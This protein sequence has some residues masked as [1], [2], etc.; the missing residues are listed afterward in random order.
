MEKLSVFLKISVLSIITLMAAEGMSCTYTFKLYDTY[1]DGWNGGYINI[2][3]NGIVVASN[4]AL[5]NGTGPLDYAINCNHGDIISTDYI[6]GS[7]SYENYYD[8]YD[9]NNQFVVRDGC[10]NYN[11]SPAGG[12]LTTANCAVR[13]VSMLKLLSPVT[14]CGLTGA[15]LVKVLVKNSAVQQIDTLYFSYSYDDGLTW[16]RDTVYLTLYGG[17]SLDYNFIQNI[18]LSSLG[19]YKIITVVTTGND[20]GGFNDT[21]ETEV[22]NLPYISTFPYQESFEA[23]TGGWYSEGTNSSWAHG[24]PDAPIIDTAATDTMAWVTN[25]TGNYNTNEK[26]WVVSPCFDFSGLTNIVFEMKLWYET[27]YDDGAALQYTTDNVN[28][29]SIGLPFDQTNWYNQGWVQG[30]WQFMS[31]EGWS[32]SSSGWV[33]VKHFLPQ[34]LAGAPWVRFRVI[35]GSTPYGYGNYEGVAFDDVRI[36]EPPP[37]TYSFSEVVQPNT[38]VVGKGMFNQEIIGLRI[39]TNSSTNPLS[40]TDIQLNTTGTTNSADIAMSRM[41][42]SEDISFYNPHLQFG[43]DVKP[44]SPFGYQDTLYLREGE[45]YFW[46]VYDVDTAATVGNFLDGVVDSIKIGGVW[47]TPSP[48]NPA[49]NRQILPP[50]AG[51]YVIDQMG[52]GDY[53]ILGDALSDLNNRG[54][55]GPVILDMLPGIYNEKPILRPVFGTSST[56][57]IT[58][59]SST[60]DS[61]AVTIQDSAWSWEENWVVLFESASHYILQHLN[62]KPLSP[63]YARAITL[64]GQCSDLQILHCL[65]E[66]A[67]NT[68]SNDTWLAILYAEG[69]DQNI[70]LEGNR[71]EDGAYGIAMYGWNGQS[72]NNII[73]ENQFENQ[74]GQGIYLEYQISPVVYKNIF[75]S[76]LN[77][78]YTGITGYSLSD[79]FRIMANQI[80]LSNSGM[81]LYITNC[82]GDTNFYGGVFNNFVSIDAVSGSSPY[83]LYLNYLENTAVMHNSVNIYNGPAP[84]SYTAYIGGYCNNLY[85]FNN[86]FSNTTTG[87]VLRINNPGG[88]WTN[89]NNYYFTGTQFGNYNY[90]QITNLPSWQN[91]SG[92][93]G[94][95]QV[96]DPMFFSNTDLHTIALA[97]SNKGMTGSGLLVD[98]D[99]DLRDTLHPD[100]GAD[101]FPEP[102]QEASFEGFVSPQDACGLGMEDISIRI[103]NNGMDPITGTLTASYQVSG[104]SVVNQMVPGTILPG[105]TLNFT[106]TTKAN[107]TAIVNDSTFEILSWISLIGDPIQYNDSGETSVKS[108]YV[109]PVPVAGNATVNY[110][111]AAVVSVSG[112]G[113]KRWYYNL[114]DSNYFHFGDTLN[115]VVLYDTTT[116]YVNSWSA[117]TNSGGGNIAPQAIASASICNTGACSNLNDLYL[118][119]CGTQQMW[120]STANP[121]D[122]T[123]HVNWIDFEWSSPRN[124][125]GLKI[126]HGQSDARLL[127]GATLYKWDGFNWISFH[128]FSNL[129]MQC[130]NE[131]V[132]PLVTTTKLRITSF[133]MTGVGQLNNPNFREIEVFEPQAMGCPSAMIPVTAYVTAFPGADAGVTALVQPA[134]QTPAGQPTEIKVMLKNYGLN[135][136]QNVSILWRLNNVVQGTFAW[137]GNL[138][139]G[140]ETMVTIDTAIFN[141]GTL[142]IQAYT[143]LPNGLP[144]NF[145]LN[146]TASLWFNACL[147]G[148]YTIGPASSGSYNYNTF[149]SAVTSLS[150]AGICGSVIFDVYPG[151]YTEQIIIPAIPGAGPN[152]TITFRGATPDSSLAILQFSTSSS[153]S[154]YTLRFNGASWITFQH[155]TLKANG[156]SYGRVVEFMGANNHIEVLNCFIKTNTT[157]TS[158]NFTCIYSSSS[159]VSVNVNLASNRLEGGYYGIYWYG[160][161]STRTKNLQVYNNTLLDFYRSG[162]YLYYNDTFNIEANWII[163]RP[164]AQVLYSIYSSNSMGGGKIIRNRILAFSNSSFYGIYLYNNDASVSPSPYLLANNYITYQGNPSG[165]A[166]GIYSYYNYNLDILYNSVRMAGGSTSSG[167]AYYQDYGGSSMRLMNNIFSNFNGGYA[168]YIYSTYMYTQVNNNDYYT[169]GGN[170]IYWDYT[171]TSFAGYQS[172]VAGQGFETMSQNLL[173][174]FVSSTNLDLNSTL[175]S[176]MASPLVNVT[177]DIF[178]HPRGNTP[179]IGAHEVPILPNDAGVFSFINP[180]PAT[181]VTEGDAVPVSVTITNYG[182]DPITSVLVSYRVNNGSPVSATYNGYLSFQQTDIFQLPAITSP[183]GNIQVCAWTTLAN[184]INTFNDT[185]CTSYYAY[186]NIDAHLTQIL[187]LQE[188]CGLGLDTV[189]VEIVNEATALLPA[190]YTAT[191]QRGTDPVVTETVNVAIPVGDTIIFT[192]NTLLSLNTSIDTTYTITAW[193]DALDDNLPGNDTA[194][195]QVVSLAIPPPPSVVSPVTIPFGTGTVLDANTLMYTEWYNSPTNAK[196]ASGSVYQTP[197]LYDTTIYYAQTFYGNSGQD[198]MIGTASTQGTTNSYPNPYGHYYWGNKEQYLI[199]ASELTTANILPGNINSVAFNVILAG[200]LP[201]QNFSIKMGHSSLSAMSSTFVTGLTEV[202]SNPVYT[203]VGGWN[204]H[205]FQTPFVWDGTSNVVVEVCFN[206]TSYTSHGYV[207]LAQPGFVS[208]INAHNDASGVCN[209]TSGSTYSVRPA[210]KM[211]CSSIGCGSGR[212]PVVVNVSNIPP[213]GKPD[214]IPSSMQVTLN[215]C[216]STDTR[217]IRIKNI[218]TAPLQYTSFGGPHVK[219]TTSTQYY[220]SSIYSDTTTH[221]FTTIPISVDSLFLEVTINGYYSTSAA[222]ASLLIEGTNLGIIPDGNI[223]YGQNITVLYAVGGTQLSN[224]MLDGELKVRIGNS[225]SVYPSYAARMHRVRA[226]TKPA[227]W[228]SMP[229]TTG[230]IPVGDSTILQVSFNGT[231]L[232]EGSY[233]ASIPLHFNHP[234]YPYV[235]IPVAMTLN[236]EPDIQTAPCITFD[237]IFQYSSTYELLTIYNTGC[238]TLLISNILVSDTAFIPDF[239]QATIPPFD[240]LDLQVNFEPKLLKTYLDTL[241]ILSNDADQKICLNA[242]SISPPVIVLGDDTLEALVT[243]CGDTAQL[244]LTISNNGNAPL[245]WQAVTNPGSRIV[246]SPD[247]GT[248]AALSQQTASI[249]LYTNGL[250]SGIYLGDITFTSNDPVTPS[251]V[252]PVVLEITGAPEIVLS[253]VTCLALDSVMNGAT[254]SQTFTII[255]NGCDTLFV[256]SLSTGTSHF[257]LA[258]PEVDILPFQQSL[259][260]VYFHPQGEGAFEDT[261]TMVSNDGIH[262]LCLTGVGLPAPVINTSQHNLNATIYQCNDSLIIPVQITNTGTAD[263]VWSIGNITGTQTGIGSGTG[264]KVGVYNSSGITNLLN[265]TTDITAVNIGSMD[266][267]TIKQYDVIMNIRGSNLN[268]ADVLAYIQAGGSWI[269][270]WSSNQ[271][272]FTWGAITGSVANTGTNGTYGANILV[273][274]HYLAQNINWASMPYGAGPTEF[275][276]DLRGINDPGA[277][278]IVTANHSSYPNNP[279]LVEK[280]YGSGKIMIFNWDY[281]DAPTYNS[282]VS[283]MII[284]VVRYAGMKAQW[285][286]VDPTADTAS[287]LGTNT[288]NVKFNALGLKSGTYNGKIFI[289]SNDPVLPTDTLFCTMDVIGAPEFRLSHTTGC[290]DFDTIIQ[291]FSSAK[292]LYLHNDGCDTLFITGI[293]HNWPQYSL[294]GTN[295]T[296]LPWD[297]AQLTITFTPNSAQNYPDTL[298]F[299]TNDGIHTLCLT[300]VGIDA[301]II[302]YSPSSLSHTFNTCNDSVMLPLTIYNTGIGDLRYNMTNL[303]GATYD[304]TSTANYTSSGASTNHT[305]TGVPTT[306][307]SMKVILT[308]NGD[309]DDASE[310]TSLI[311]EGTNIGIVPDNNYANGTYITAQ[312]SF[313][314]AQLQSWIINGILNITLANSGNV[315]HWSGLVSMHSVQVIVNG[316]PWI[317]V[318]KTAD[319]VVTGDSSIV[320]VTIKTANLNNGTYHSDLKILSNDPLNQVILVPC[321]LTVNGPASLAVSDPCLHFGSAMQYSSKKDTLIITNNGC[322]TLSISSIYTATSHYSLS[323][324]YMILQPGQQGQLIVTFAPTGVGSFSDNIYLVTGGGTQMVCLTG[325]GVDASILNVTPTSFSKTINTCN[326]TIT[327]I[328]QVQ[329]LGTGNLTYQVYGG[330]GLSGDSTVLV[331]RDNHP[332]GVNIEQYLLNNFGVTAQTILSSQIAAAN[333]NLYDVIITVGDQ[334]T[335]YYNTLTSQVAKFNTFTNSGGIIL[336]MLGNYAAN[337]ITLA[338]NATMIYGSS[339]SQNIITDASHPIVQGLSNPLNGNN[340]NANYLSNLPANADIITR[341]NLSSQPTT[342]QYEVG[343]GLVIA[344][345]M[346][347]EYNSQYTAYSMSP[348]MHNALSYALGVIGTSPSWMS[349]AYTSDTLFGVGSTNVAVNFNSTGIPNGV[350][351]SNIIV[352]SNDPV[353]PQILVPCTLNVNGVAQFATGS[354]CLDFDTVIQGASAQGAIMIYNTG[355]APLVVTSV[356]SLSTEYTPAAGVFTV[357]AGDSFFL[358]VAFAPLATGNRNSTL[359]I[360]SNLGVHPVCLQ[361]I[362]VNPPVIGVSP[363]FFSNVINSCSDTVMQTLTLSNTGTGQA[364]YHIMGLYGTDIDQSS[365]IPFVT[366]GAVTTHTFSNLPPN[367]D[368]LVLEISLSGDF[369]QA[370]EFATLIVDGTSIGQIDDGDIT[371]GTSFTDYFGFG[372]AQLAAMIAN[373]QIVVNIQNAS[374]VDHWSGLNSFHQVRL[375]VNGNHWISVSPLSDTIPSNSSAQVTLKFFSTN[376]NAGTHYYDVVIGS[377][378]PGNAQVAVPC[379]LTVIGNANWSIGQNCLNF[380]SIMVGASNMRYLSITNTGCDTLKIISI[381]STVLEIAPQQTSLN[382]MPGITYQLPVVFTP[383]QP[384]TLTGNLN[385]VSN[386]GQAAVCL[387]AKGLPAPTVVV[388]QSSFNSNMACALIDVKPM[389]IRN[390]GQ[391]PLVFSLVPGPGSFLTSDVWSGTILPGDSVTVLFTFNKTGI[392]IGNF[393]YSLNLNSNDPVNPAILLT[394]TLE[395][396]T[397]VIPV[398]LGPDQ[399]VCANQQVVLNAGSGYVSYLWENSSTDSVRTITTSG[400]YSITVM[401]GNNCPSSDTIT[402]VVH[403]IPVVNAGTDTAIC[404]GSGFERDALATGTIMSNGLIQIGNGVSYSGANQATPFTT[405]YMTARRQIIVLNNEMKSNG[406]KRGTLQSMAFNIGSVGDP[407]LSSFYISIGSTTMN[408]LNAGFK[409]NLTQVYYSANQT[410]TNGWN[411]FTFNTPYYFNGMDN[412]VIE[413]C[414]TNTSNNYNSS[415]QYHNPGFYCQLYQYS[416]NPVVSGCSL[417]GGYISAQRPNI[418]FGGIIDGGSYTWTGPAGYHSNEPVLRINPVLQPNAGFYTLMVDNGIGCYATDAFNLALAA[419]PIVNAGA[420]TFIYEGQSAQLNGV[421]TGGQPPYTYQW[422]PSASLNNAAILTPIAS[423]TQTTLF[424]LDAG[425]SNGCNS[426]DT[427]QLTVIPRYTISGTLT[428]NNA[429]YT[430]I[431]NAKVYLRNNLAVVID[432][433]VTDQSGGFNFYLNPPGT[434]SLAAMTGKAWGGVN[435]TDA[436]VVQRHVINLNPL[437]GLRITGADVNNSSTVSSTDALLVLRRTLALDTVFTRGDWVYETPTFTITSSNVTRNIQALATGD[438]NGSYVPQM[439]RQYPLVTV[440]CTGEIPLSDGITSVPLNVTENIF[441]GA[442]TLFMDLPMES[443]SDLSVAS[444]LPGLMFHKDGNR[445]K[446]V[447]SDEK[448]YFLKQGETLCTIS[449]KADKLPSEQFWFNP[450]LESELADVNALVLE[451]VILTAPELVVA[452]AFTS[453]IDIYNQPN[454]FSDQTVVHYTLPEAGTVKIELFDAVGKQLGILYEG[455]NPAEANTLKIASGNLPAGVY[456]LS[457]ALDTGAAVYRKDHSL[458]LIR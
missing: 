273:P 157:S 215:G 348:M 81:G 354:Q 269:G 368:S 272:P 196:I 256:S 64:T 31:P 101:E 379:T 208:T 199:L 337:T 44:L 121:P 90:N 424:R 278:I 131:V 202:Y 18:N 410:L 242:V 454:P 440:S 357:A 423:P 29:N 384:G 80:H 266:F 318:D 315:D 222:Y 352:Y 100:L 197:L 292:S 51:T 150:S 251:I 127:T 59:K 244:S 174:P 230:S 106:F 370:S 36:Y 340:A 84:S 430:P 393:T 274:N 233:N 364:I 281:N 98:I 282:V 262:Q 314:G 141:P 406:F 420:S 124:I 259:V 327:D 425:G 303:F 79:S 328:L 213:L 347:W 122:P 34:A 116:Y 404:T 374:T 216:N 62:I 105:D 97:L 236:G 426:W 88:I 163:N 200:S 2:K 285:I 252:L 409:G 377:N 439:M 362:C 56:N 46:L 446:I 343:S 366:S 144:D 40:L 433:V 91:I 284:Q 130:E 189:R 109:P 279:L 295:F 297:S 103:A 390:T 267:N 288:L 205:N 191:Y 7:W 132:F 401:D 153:T 26:S 110:G 9:N 403:P 155:L 210:M 443:L 87:G 235:R 301:P 349:F 261:V 345:G 149:S 178:G 175:L 126:H 159:S 41:Y 223:G 287:V 195:T 66:G 168:M 231:G 171:H 60:N 27:V 363:A 57:T 10:N 133:Q 50:M 229:L 326:D 418:R 25:L 78:S 22:M 372:G 212:I 294:S 14:G 201:L 241:T 358:Q 392:P 173:P 63:D 181:I 255:N 221:I 140:A 72:I 104:G 359:N 412:L 86:V 42:Y 382:I 115:T 61:T 296:L 416:Y 339:E 450:A 156:T 351:H 313:S 333:F 397:M 180:T 329:N 83:G 335:S 431:N 33:T 147:S 24:V 193:V 13:D 299:Q 304:Q 39:V 383:L 239:T 220:S 8:L 37:M 375:R 228:I 247:N 194:F 451:P 350:Y 94:S 207:S 218:G 113:F 186:S 275:M 209:Y 82:I 136:L 298:A 73:A 448:G 283:N 280:N 422:T 415:V 19:T 441:L 93:D 227:P 1:G 164:T 76:G 38:N 332:W 198:F 4:I 361:G 148:T 344:T 457:I 142:S 435:S 77:S 99:G 6:P 353:T 246:I 371:A 160:S 85:V 28:W 35:F 367:I 187:P 427:M 112:P 89:Y 120:I 114:N 258:V 45:N 54:V 225:S 234:G 224:W 429:A 452:S 421:V 203:H 119:T 146:D 52:L 400:T 312:Y 237:S 217:N 398:N 458:I 118:G 253:P 172:Y 43:A 419:V 15:E 428:Y 346:L 413:I 243:V 321:T 324:S 432:S 12:Y 211:A 32:G 65:L 270:E 376:V 309:Y 188:G 226:F 291:G 23:N 380:D 232:T 449:F 151:T 249:A 414:F 356:T 456:H 5:G 245:T 143:S 437:T 69:S 30:L 396:P 74:Y 434:Y 257:S 47:Y 137:T 214:V 55:S 49:G 387:N 135:T 219:D 58:I 395:N 3:V 325:Q 67:P 264:M 185:S 276:R 53:Q 70:T 21:L 240:S 92:M 407:P 48:T 134:G 20:E 388:S 184:D 158:S 405:G 300:G 263:L 307:D 438:V 391:A 265:T 411:T 323:A 176:E 161:S 129:P 369:D 152:A 11:C 102:L 179:T 442:L 71:F 381:Q 365:H 306:S 447:W 336:Y 338:G 238:D 289:Q 399:A 355:C 183:A 302:S 386:I 444:D 192:F 145:N 455:W 169:T 154:N 271:Y 331:I 308:I 305:F 293:P 330:R 166:Y 190:G 268:Q 260:T 394:F 342:V 170:I 317:S 167:I 254:T 108:G 378:D 139:H 436:L 138:A 248:I 117:F 162:I 385:L 107:L 319:T 311:I 417:T 206:N 95:S 290:L 334:S 453:Q 320:M 182:H 445:L 310:Y 17:D 111:N 125:N 277:V 16:T 75:H 408:N 177:N 204:V 128:T 360:T 68:Q 96:A 322:N 389:K 341:T 286:T 165:S 123:P 316:I 402:I 373:G 250:A